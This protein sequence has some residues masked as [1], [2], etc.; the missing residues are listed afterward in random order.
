MSRGGVL[1]LCVSLGN[2]AL[3]R[4]GV[5]SFVACLILAQFAGAQES[6]QAPPEQVTLQTK[7]GIPLKATYYPGS[8]GKETIPIV[9]LHSH[10]GNRNDFEQL[11]RFFQSDYF[12]AA[13]LVPDLRGHGESTQVPGSP[14]P[15]SADKLNAGQFKAMVTQDMEACKKFLMDRHNK[16]ELNIE[17]LTLIG[18]EMGASVAFLYAKSDWSWPPLATGKQGQDVRA[19]ALISPQTVFKGLKLADGMA[20]PDPYGFRQNVQ[21]F[22]AVGEEDPKALKDADRLEKQIRRFRAAEPTDK[23]EEL[24]LV[25]SRFPTNLQG[26]DLVAQPSFE[27]HNQLAQF[28]DFRV[29]QKAS[30]FPWKER[31]SPIGN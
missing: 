9:M 25:L 15:L 20:E 13:V 23:P 10:K 1:P 21:I 18:A 8:N 4:Y 12:G 7:D 2:R 16:G 26:K 14:R 30:E 5:L 31:K 17:Q 29:K 28:V 27:L 19:V 22:V 11:A 6:K 24:S 3:A